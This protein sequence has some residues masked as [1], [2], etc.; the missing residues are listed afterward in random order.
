MIEDKT[1]THQARQASAI[2]R[3]YEMNTDDLRLIEVLLDELPVAD[4]QHRL[5]AKTL[6]GV[7]AFGAERNNIP[8]TRLEHAQAVIFRALRELATAHAIPF[9]GLGALPGG[10]PPKLD[11]GVS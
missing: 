7:E 8:T 3:I 1:T 4:L 11:G 6:T 10:D 9:P 5:R 2:R